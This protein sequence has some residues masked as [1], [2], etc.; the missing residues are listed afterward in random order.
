MSLRRQVIDTL[1]NGQSD[2]L[3][4]VIKRTKGTAVSPDGVVT[5][6]FGTLLVMD[7]NGNDADGDV[8]Y[9]VTA[10]KAIG[11]SWTLC[12]DAS[13]LGHVES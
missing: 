7:Y 11:S 13:V 12:Y 4:H 9:N 6:P 10:A 8:Y 3:A 1:F 2:P 5:A